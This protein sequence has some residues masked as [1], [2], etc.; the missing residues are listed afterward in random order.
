MT[1]VE[2]KLSSTEL[3]KKVTKPIWNIKKIMHRKVKH[4]NKWL[5]N[6]RLILQ[7]CTVYQWVI[8]QQ[9][10]FIHQI[11]MQKQMK[12]ML[13]SAAGLV[14]DFGPTGPMVAL[15]NPC[16]GS[17]QAHPTIRANGGWSSPWGGMDCRH[18]ESFAYF[19]LNSWTFRVQTEISISSR[20]Q[21]I[22]GLGNMGGRCQGSTL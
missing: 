7:G 1:I 15:S 13:R 2:V 19:A 20:M 5:W 22:H 21:K 9:H 8:E 10:S 16:L 18:Q 4:D 6:K 3:I 17:L 12:P 11:Q 14:P